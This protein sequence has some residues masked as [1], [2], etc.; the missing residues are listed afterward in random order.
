MET[1]LRGRLAAAAMAILV[2]AAAVWPYRDAA[3]YF[4][5]GVDT[6]T[7]IEYSRVRSPGDVGRLLTTPLMY[8]PKKF[9]AF[10]S[11]L[12]FNYRPLS[13]LTFAADYALWKLNPLG[14]HLRDLAI[15]AA[16][17]VLLFFVLAALFAGDR[18]AALLGS[19]I[20][21]AHP[22]LAEAVPCISR[23]QDP[24]AALF[25]LLSLR[26][27]ML[28]AGGGRRARLGMP[29]SAAAF[30]LAVG[31]KETA[32]ILPGAALLW[33]LLFGAERGRTPLGPARAAAKIAPY[34]AVLAAYGAWRFVLA[35]RL[36]GGAPG[37][38]SGPAWSAAGALSS[39]GAYVVGLADP[40]AF[41]A[42]GPRTVR[43][44]LAV[45]ALAAAFLGLLL[46]AMARARRRPSPGGVNPVADP[47][48]IVVFLAAWSIL[49]AVLYLFLGRLSL[50]YLYLPAAPFSALLGFSLTWCLR[51]IRGRRTEGEGTA[52]RV[53]AP[54]VA[55]LAATLLII[56]TALRFTPML[57]P[58]R[59]WEAAGAVGRAVLAA[60]DETAAALPPGTV[61]R[62]CSLPSGTR[63]FDGVTPR[64]RQV[65]YLNVHSLR[66]WLR[67]KYPEEGYGVEVER[68]VR[69][70]GVPAAFFMEVE[71]VT[72]KRAF[73]RLS[74][75]GES[76]PACRQGVTAN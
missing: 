19:L 20:F 59:Q 55:A 27:L 7:L 2:A 52:G 35:A 73:V 61:L 30:L 50:Y 8:G 32:V 11:P 26:L 76:L 16:V 72:G 5:T 28:S 57:R 21:A 71:R 22:V 56:W 65:S 14:Y 3:R 10:A 6:L 41:F 37:P 74:A 54:E 42:R 29:L 39:L 46:A 45:L 53:G 58:Y 48:R 69:L 75:P 31:A 36:A 66:S 34:A 64:A 23:R 17:S 18:A 70:K 43:G 63:A 47:V 49:P 38:T 24:L 33:L 67:L 12:L 15:H 60:L 51:R 62:L 25:M 40:T 1:P 13:S 4:F 9:N 68:R 44:A